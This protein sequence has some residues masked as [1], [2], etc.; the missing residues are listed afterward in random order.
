MAHNNLT[1]FICYTS[2]IYGRNIK[3]LCAHTKARCLEESRIVFK[4]Y[5]HSYIVILKKGI[6][7]N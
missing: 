2:W 4:F 1:T 6:Q 3:G 7:K 5:R